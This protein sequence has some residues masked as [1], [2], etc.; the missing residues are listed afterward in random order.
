MLEGIIWGML[1]DMA[2]LAARVAREKKKRKALP[3]DIVKAY[4]L[5]KEKYIV[6]DVKDII[7]RMTTAVQN[8]RK[9]IEK[10]LKAYYGKTETALPEIHE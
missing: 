5:H 9:E 4:Q 8:K 6:S 1:E 3:E 10:E 2:C 7:D